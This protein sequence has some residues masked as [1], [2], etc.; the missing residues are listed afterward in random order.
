VFTCCSLTEGGTRLSACG[1]RR[2]L[3]RSRSSPAPPEDSDSFPERSACPS[4][5]QPAIRARPI[6]AGFR[7]GYTSRQVMTPVPRVYLFGIARRA[8][9]IQRC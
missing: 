1:I 8:H 2:R 7:G 6:S 5:R 4:L 3:L 9:A